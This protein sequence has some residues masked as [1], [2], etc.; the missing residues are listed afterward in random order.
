MT[1]INESYYKDLSSKITEE[2]WDSMLKKL[3]VSTALGISGIGYILIKQASA[4]TQVAFRNFASRCLETGKILLKWKIGQ[5]YPIP[6]DV[7]WQFNLSNIRPIALLEIFRK[8]VIKVFTT[9]LEK[10]IREN[11]ILEGS[12]YARLIGSSTESPIHILS[13]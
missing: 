6:K 4:E 8:C 3:K 11:N 10:I 13:M 9:R 5:T 7:D 2:E 1:R 12:N